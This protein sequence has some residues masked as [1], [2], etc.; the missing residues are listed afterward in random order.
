MPLDLPELRRR[1]AKLRKTLNNFSKNPTVDRVHDLR[2]RTRRVESILHA[3]DLDRSGSEKKLLDGLK[4]V[5]KKAGA[6]RDM[7][8]LT[9]HVLELGTKED[10]NCVVRLVHHLGNQRQRKA[11]KLYSTLKQDGSKLRT[12][13]KHTRRHLDSALRMS[14]QSPQTLD[15][16]RAGKAPLHAISNTLLLTQEL[17]DVKRLGRDNLHQYRIG[18]KQLRYVLEMADES[19]DGQPR[20]MEE[21][22][23]VQDAIGE[24][25]DWVQLE[26][27]ARKVLKG[28]PNCR[29]IKKIH[30]IS[31]RKFAEGI[32][33]TERMRRRYLIV[34][35]PKNKRVSKRTRARVPGPVLVAA[36]EMA[37]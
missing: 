25:H 10:P 11:A 29:L 27:I 15:L 31:E 36:S 5:R 23:T 28:D 22:K 17:A 16:T 34:P 12:R 2:T 8:V 30:D 33:L 4:A 3:L 32:R 7:D 21:L 9:S 19:E 20:F 37:A 14:Q 26:H 35:P 6:V 24:W 1:I 13:L 18:V